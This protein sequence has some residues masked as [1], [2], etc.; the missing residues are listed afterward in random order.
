MSAEA[1]AG[2]IE[3][4]R[5]GSLAEL[6]ALLGAGNEAVL[7]LQQLF[8]LAQGYGYADYLQL[9]TSCVRGLA[10]YTGAPCAAHA[11]PPAVCL[12]HCACQR[13]SY[14]K[15]LSM[16]D[17]NMMPIARASTCSWATAWRLHHLVRSC[18]AA[19]LPANAKRAR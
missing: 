2:I 7:E 13:G 18:V 5:V 16:M 3:A 10:Y 8:S 19:A 9:D 1:S 17:S 15:Y 4:T 11:G 12:L 14:M 6:E